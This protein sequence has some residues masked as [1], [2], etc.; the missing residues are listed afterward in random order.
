MPS[1]PLPVSLVE[2]ALADRNG[3]TGTHRFQ[4]QTN[5]GGLLGFARIASIRVQTIFPLI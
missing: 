3:P 2:N 4:W 1:I 5:S